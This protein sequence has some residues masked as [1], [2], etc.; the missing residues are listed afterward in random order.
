MG[1]VLGNAARDVNRTDG[2]PPSYFMAKGL[3][4]FQP[5]QK[6]NHALSIRCIACFSYQHGVPLARLGR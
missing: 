2:T 3:D 6:K 5:K 1:H 4:A